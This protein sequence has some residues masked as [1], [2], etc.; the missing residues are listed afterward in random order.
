MNWLVGLFFFTIAH[1]STSHY[2]VIRCTVLK[3]ERF[4]DFHKYDFMYNH[5]HT[6]EN[7]ISKSQTYPG[8]M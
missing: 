3:Y 8:F 7:K 4:V 2:G 5:I 1:T 6:H